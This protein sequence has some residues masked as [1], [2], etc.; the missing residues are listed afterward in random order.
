MHHKNFIYG[1]LLLI[2][3]SSCSVSSRIKKADKKFNLGEYYTAGNMYKRIYPS[4]PQKN[5]KL[6]AEVAY[7]TGNSYR[8]INQDKKA[9]LAYKNAIRYKYPDIGF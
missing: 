5:K 1:L 6:R 8:I 3:L 9:E 7:K 4:V 2:I